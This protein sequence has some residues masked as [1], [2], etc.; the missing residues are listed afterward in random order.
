M[1]AILLAAMCLYI[2]FVG[3]WRCIDKIFYKRNPHVDKI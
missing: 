2:L 3:A 1:G